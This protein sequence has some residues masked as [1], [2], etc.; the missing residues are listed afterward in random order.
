MS[1]VVSCYCII[2]VLRVIQCYYIGY[3]SLVISLLL[4]KN[5]KERMRICQTPLN[6][7]Y[8]FI[9]SGFLCKC[10]LHHAF[11]LIRRKG[12]SKLKGF[13]NITDADWTPFYWSILH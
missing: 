10:L 11:E 2:S 6:L 13:V 1:S 7:S 3:N 12:H 4:V 5:G 8:L 9:Y